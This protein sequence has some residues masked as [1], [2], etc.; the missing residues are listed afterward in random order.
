MGIGRQ[1]GGAFTL[2]VAALLLVMPGV[3]GAVTGTTITV[4]TGGDGASGCTL[5]HA[6]ETANSNSNAPGCSAAGL[7]AGG[8]DVIA[9]PATIPSPIQLSGGAIPLDAGTVAGGFSLQGPG[10]ALMDVRGTATTRVFEVAGSGEASRI[11]GITISDG[12]AVNG[13]VG[14]A[15]GG[16][17]LA[18]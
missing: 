14:G 5:R 13:S 2:A 18:S 1:T 11:S 8:L 12:N 4:D 15:T 6:A 9:I 3:A 17:F 16:G 7:V 10:A